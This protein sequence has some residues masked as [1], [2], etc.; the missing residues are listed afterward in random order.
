MKLVDPL[1]Y[2]VFGNVD[3]LLQFFLELHAVD[4]VQE[5]NL[6][7]VPVYK[8]FEIVDDVLDLVQLFGFDGVQETHKVHVVNLVG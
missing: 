4:E 6:F 2:S 3:A 7:H 5:W 1:E 8:P